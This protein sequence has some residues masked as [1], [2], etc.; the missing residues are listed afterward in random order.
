VL[1]ALLATERHNPESATL[2]W[3][4]QSGESCDQF[5]AQAARDTIPPMTTVHVRQ[6]VLPDLDDLA[7]LLNEFRDFQGKA[8]DLAGARQ[9]LLD[10]FNHGESVVFVAHAAGVPAGFA[11]LYPSFSST[12]L[13][14]VFILNDLYVRNAGRRRGVASGLLTAIE[15]Y[16]WTFGAV[17]VTLNVARTGGHGQDLYEARG[18]QQDQEHFMYH[19]FGPAPD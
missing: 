2:L 7:L 19:R 14:R 16:A 15:E 18:W 5:G 8:S 17:R 13:A 10:R 12:A 4:L 3:S 9:F 1:C 6:A 11:Q